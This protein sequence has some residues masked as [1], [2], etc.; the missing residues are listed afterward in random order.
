MIEAFQGLIRELLSEDESRLSP[1]RKRLQ[2]ALGSSGRVMIELIPELALLVGEQP[3]VPGLGPTEARNRFN[4][5]FQRFVQ[6][7]A[8]REHPL[9]LY[10]DDLQWADAASLGLIRALLEDPGARHLLIIGA[11]RDDAGGGAQALSSPLAELR[12]A[13]A[14]LT[15]IALRPLDLREV[16]RLL[17]DTLGC[18]DDPA[19]EPLAGLVHDRAGGNPFFVNQLVTWFHARGLFTFSSRAR[20][21]EWSLPRLEAASAAVSLASLMMD[22][23]G[24]LSG[25]SKHLV[26]L[27]ACL[28][29][30]FDLAT[31]AVLG[32]S[33]AA[34]AAAELEGAIESGLV[35]PIGD[36]YKYLPTEPRLIR[37]QLVHE[38]AREAAY[39]Q[40][41]AEDVAALHLRIGRLLLASLS[42]A[43]RAAR[44]FEIV[45]QLDPGVDLLTDVAE[46]DQVARLDLLAAEHAYSATAYQVAL[47]R[48]QIATR[49]LGADSWQR[50]P[51]LTL[52]IHLL[53]AGC[54]HLLGHVEAALTSLEAALDGTTRSAE[55][56]RIHALQASIHAS[57]GDHE[58]A[59]RASDAALARSGV[60]VP[61]PDQ[62]DAACAAARAKLAKGL[63]GRP[64]ADL[65]RLAEATDSAA[66]ARAALL[67]RSLIER[68]FPDLRLSS[69]LST[70]LVNDS[71]EHGVSPGS[72][73]G[74]VTVALTQAATTEDPE[75]AH[76]LGLVALG[77]ASRL[78]DVELRARVELRFSAFVNP[79]HRALR[80]SYPF[81]ERSYTALLESG[82]PG[83]AG[84]AA[85]QSLF[86]ALLGGDE[87]QALQERA[88]RHH[89]AQT[90]LGHADNA[91]LMACFL[92]AT[93][94]LIRGA[95]PP[96]H[97]AEIG[98][99]TVTARLTG[100]VAARFT[101]ELLEMIVAFL[102]GD[103]DRALAL[104]TRAAAHVHAV[105]GHLAEAEFRFFRAL[106]TAA[107]LPTSTLEERSLRLALLEEDRAKI[108]A[109]AG[110]CPENFGYKHHLVRA[111]EARVRGDNEAAMALYD[112][113]IE[114]AA[115]QEVTHH[116]ALAGEL[117]ARFY[118]A[119]GRAKIARGYLTE[120][121]HAYLRWGAVARV[122]ALD[123]QH[124]EL[125]GRPSLDVRSGGEGPSGAAHDTVFQAC[126]AISGEL[127][128]DELLRKLMSTVLDQA[129]AQR[130]LLWLA[131]DHEIIVEAGG[132]ASS[133]L[134]S[135][136]TLDDRS[137]LSR[138]IVRC[139]E[140]TRESVV[141]GDAANTGQ[142]RSDPHVATARPKSI[143][144]VPILSRQQLVGVLYLE[145]NLVVSAFTP[146]RC[147]VVERLAAQAAVSLANAR[148]HDTLDSRVKL[149]TQELSSSND[150]LSLTLR[151]LKDT[152]KQL[153][154]QEKLASLGAL[155]SGIAHEIKNPL[156]FI[157]NFAELSVELTGDLLQEIDGQSARLDPDS[158]AAIREIIGDLRQNSAK[159]HEHGRRADEVVRA[160]LGHA[161]GGGGER[162]EVSVNALLAEYTSLAYQGF[163]SQDTAFNVSIETSYDPAVG[164]MLL[165]SQEIG[166]VFL[167]LINNA[168]YAARAQRLRLGERFSPTIRVATKSLGDRVEIRVRDNGA[169]IPPSVRDKIF[170]PFFT[171]K[172]ASDG[173]GLGL[174]ISHEIV[175]T[176]GGTLAFE[177]AEGMYTEFIVT[178]PRHA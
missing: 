47:V 92:R 116:Q 88:Q 148:L 176:N 68:E 150:E 16:R 120:A 67:A 4:L 115:E 11:H 121:R 153:I 50:E 10:L 110:G 128:L 167:N 114:G 7:F 13:Q 125:L 69:L 135:D 118:L 60:E 103:T 159:I 142:F 24:R 89:D 87:L 1:L 66:R 70:R 112:Q 59:L 15:E 152:Q 169:G 54:E 117:A 97:E 99:A 53:R 137:D 56:A 62:L 144:C 43:E 39:A 49:L 124:S 156:N 65:V 173:T 130:G 155:T 22:R 109:W 119:R 55:K 79:W 44:I 170:N 36:E 90:R 77:L 64:I 57:R 161:R 108:A 51:E 101:H 131:G 122:A 165:P 105:A 132:G 12:K 171:T 104:S 160:M 106:L 37:Y 5:V 42:E 86:L 78:D 126:L 96:E 174:S 23:I 162:R 158:V 127:V 81:L 163:R 147:R 151:R 178:L 18:P 40:I 38:Q 27:S 45:T 138:A 84:I 143:L 145:N 20:R 85:A 61:P 63:S 19:V 94:L 52:A 48:L 74:Y 71:L 168:C 107:L 30:S 91:G 46:R 102:A 9:A 32:E 129:G 80:T 146:E 149:R 154:V 164:N 58:A 157:N 100:D 175:E 113:A 31:L 76:A 41:P 29:P 141:L 95:I 28:G 75:A 111:E 3:E 73:M 139:V 83:G 6:V 172:P 14:P 8:R 136:A 93:T 134:V 123:T 26:R 33:T 166:R 177:T 82:S 35:L 72:S 2:E 98:E 25:P 34:F 17:V 140:R 21:W 133:I